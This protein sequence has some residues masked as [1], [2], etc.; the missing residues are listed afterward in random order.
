MPLDQIFV[1]PEP[2]FTLVQHNG[3]NALPGKIAGDQDAVSK[4]SVHGIVVITSQPVANVITDDHSL[5]LN[6]G[7]I[8]S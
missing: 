7:F 3:A 2:L 6:S 1:L 5:C 4:P 8:C